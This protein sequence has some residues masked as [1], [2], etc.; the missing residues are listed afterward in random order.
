[1]EF[2]LIFD[3][4]PEKFDKYRVRYCAELFSCLIAKAGVNAESEVLELGPG[5]G[6]AT[7]PI[8]DTG[9]KYTAIELGE[10][11][12][13]FM[14]KKYSGRSNFSIINDDFITHDF[15]NER[16]D[17]VY[18]AATIQWIPEQ[19]AFGKCF[20]LLKPGGTL[21]ML[22]MVN[23]DYKSDNEALYDD[24]QKVYAEHFKPETEYAHRG[25][26]YEDALKYGFINYETAEFH[27]V[28]TYNADEYAEYCG[29][30]CDH[31]VIPEP[32]STAFFEGLRNAVKKHGDRIVF[33]D[34]FLLRTAVK[35][36]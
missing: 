36:L 6:Q 8:L 18:S 5:T 34:T 13:E 15:G 10:H 32:H 30:H 4:I 20:G 19:T 27:G 16:F 25:Y 14:R 2:R 12:A 24:I 11:L 35:P 3:T 33:N 28:R 7:E 26:R 1:M 9:C 29:T 21:A 31:M 23:S 22:S 17:L